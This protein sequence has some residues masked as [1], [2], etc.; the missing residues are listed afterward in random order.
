MQKIDPLQSAHGVAAAVVLVHHTLMVFQSDG[1][2]AAAARYSEGPAHMAVVF[3]FVLSGFVLTLSLERRGLSVTSI[4]SFLVRR[5]FRIFPAIWLA[6]A[7]GLA[8]L[9]LV[10]RP[11]LAH[12]SAWFD[13]FYPAGHLG[14]GTLIACLLGVSTL[15]V[16]PAWSIFVELV[17][18]ALM[19]ALVW[20]RR[21]RWMP[22]ALFIFLAALSFVLSGRNSVG[23]Y[24][25]QFALGALVAGATVTIDR[26]HVWAAVAVTVAL[27]QIR[28]SLGLAYHHPTL[29]IAEAFCASV[30][31]LAI[32]ASSQGLLTSKAAAHVGDVSYS[33]YALHFPIMSSLAV[34]IVSAGLNGLVAQLALTLGTFGLTLA[35][36][37]TSYRFVEKPGI[38][39][40]KFFTDALEAGRLDAVGAT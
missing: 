10:H 39:I 23:V 6:T 17:G 12:T 33:L 30:F 35:L 26:R 34:L 9:T 5:G 2:L 3:F 14:A 29:A 7:L 40:G 24:L 1:L 13:Q 22:Y 27:F 31:V 37:G 16:V 25:C 4:G 15:L 38:R 32:K 19:P 36:A 20:A 18:S 8:Y 11:N 28:Y 21:V